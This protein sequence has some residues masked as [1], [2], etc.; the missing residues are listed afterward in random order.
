M[1]QDF[2]NK[3]VLITG[4]TGSWGNELTRQL[5]KA[6]VKHIVIFSRNEF[7]QFTMKQKFQDE[8]L[9]FVIGDV[10]DLDQLNYAMQDID[11][12]FHLAALKHIP[13]CELYPM[14]TVKTNILGVENI[15]KSAIAQK[16]QKVINVSSDKATYPLNIYGM[17]KAIGEK[18]IINANKLSSTQFVC[19]RGGNVLGSNGSVV[20]VFIKSVTEE[21]KIRI[22]DKRMTRFFLSLPE[23]ISLLLVA[24][25]TSISGGIFVMKMPACRITDLADVIIDYIC[26]KEN[27]EPLNVTIEEIGMRPGEKIHEVLINEYEAPN[28]YEYGED[29]YVISPTD[30]GLKKIETKEYSSN[31]KLLDTNGI[32]E[33]L[34][35][36][37]FIC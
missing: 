28:A 8:R 16:V 13:V 37:E 1:I 11:I 21:H 25:N 26:T 6:G 14:E 9:Q 17:A 20:P 34:K 24:S 10:R 30:I 5:L 4:G 2:S 23:A 32:I 22:T 15:I 31:D 35:K 7:A 36:G 18:L 19:V 27:I 3:S 12:V 29:Y 33:L